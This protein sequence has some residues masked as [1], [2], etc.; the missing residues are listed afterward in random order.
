MG[1]IINPAKDVAL[2]KSDT[3]ARISVEFGKNNWK[4]TKKNKEIE[5][6]NNIFEINSEKD[7]LTNSKKLRN[8]IGKNN[9]N[10][11]TKN[12]IN[13]QNK[14]WPDQAIILFPEKPKVSNNK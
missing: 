5:I 14:P 11:D 8:S 13:P 6:V 12:S 9:T 1:I 4:N 7:L 10:I 3:S 2:I